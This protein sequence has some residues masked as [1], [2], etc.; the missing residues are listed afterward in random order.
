MPPAEASTAAPA[1]SIETTVP[2]ILVAED[3]IVNQ[4]VVMRMLER[5]GYHAD[6]VANG[7]EAV[8]A[9]VRFPYAAILMDRQMPDM[10]GYEATGAIRARE[11]QSGAGDSARVPIVALTANAPVADRDRITLLPSAR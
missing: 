1:P 3:N 10:D 8:A 5:P 4:R 11:Q 6:V 7:T 2:R 9:I